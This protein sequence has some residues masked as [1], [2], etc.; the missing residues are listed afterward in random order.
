MASYLRA[1]CRVCPPTN[2]VQALREK[3]AGDYV[4]ETQSAAEVESDWT[5]FYQCQRDGNIV[6]EYSAAKHDV[7]AFCT[8]VRNKIGRCRP[9]YDAVDAATLSVCE[10]FLSPFVSVNTP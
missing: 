4:Y 9:V 5:W 2:C 1:G 7:C 8:Q 10:T 3:K 6:S